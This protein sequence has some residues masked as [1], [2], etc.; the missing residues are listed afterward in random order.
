MPRYTVEVQRL[1]VHSVDVEADS[2]QQARETVDDR[3][4]PL[5][6][7]GEWE[8]LKGCEYIVY[9]RN[10]READEDAPERDA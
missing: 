4:F 7:T 9:D 8:A 10:G 3:S 5:P 1:I 6:P 2:P